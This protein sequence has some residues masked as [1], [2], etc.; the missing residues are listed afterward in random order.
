M[1]LLCYVFVNGNKAGE[2]VGIVKFGE[3][4][5]YLAEVDH[6]SCP[7]FNGPRYCHGPQPS[8]GHP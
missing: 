3:G 4:G 5:Y 6:A 2:R 7:E 1:E 8:H